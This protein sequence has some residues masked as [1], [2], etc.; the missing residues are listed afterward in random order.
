MAGEE[1]GLCSHVCLVPLPLFCSGFHFP[2]SNVAL[3]QCRRRRRKRSPS[4][5]GVG[6]RA[7]KNFVLGV[8]FVALKLYYDY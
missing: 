5:L 2:V 1:S 8:P 7:G 4:G 3:E 6:F